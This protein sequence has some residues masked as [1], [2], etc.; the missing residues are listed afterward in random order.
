MCGRFTLGNRDPDRLA[1]ELAIRREAVPV[2]KPRYNIAPTDEHI[3]VRMRNEERE[4][5]RARWGL[6]NSWAKDSSRAA[7][8]INAR[9]ERVDRTPAFRSAFQHRRCLVPADGFYEWT[10]GKGKRVP[11]WFHSPVDELLLF[12]GLYESWQPEPDTWER[13]FTIVTTAANGF[14]SPYHDRMPVI[15]SPAASDVWVDPG[16]TSLD[17]LRTLLEP[18]PDDVLAERTVSTAANSVKNDYPELILPASLPE[19]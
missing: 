7:R 15:L 6:V 3:V 10:G 9:G 2:L 1:E 5:L 12:A 16:E 4:V 19:G 18:P 8:Q 11:H 14:M 17:V 13:T